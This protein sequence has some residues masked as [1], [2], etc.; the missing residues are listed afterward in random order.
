MSG[1]TTDSSSFSDTRVIGRVKWFNN[2]AGFGFISVLEGEKTGED[3][4]AHHS[5]ISVESEQYK[6]LV[7]GEYVEFQLRSSDNEEHPYQAGEV[8]G[9]KGG[10][11]MCETRM[12]MRRESSK[13]E[14]GDGKRTRS[15]NNNNSRRNPRRGGGGPRDGEYSKDSGNR[16]GGKWN[17]S[18][19]QEE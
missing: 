11:L 15:S 13:Y 2:R 9:V 18:K 5:G 7:Q 4:F 3:V 8:K 6:Y 12:A 14:E 10:M 17:V 16:R 1:T 19:S